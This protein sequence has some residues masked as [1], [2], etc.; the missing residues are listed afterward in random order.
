MRDAVTSAQYENN[1]TLSYKT[2]RR[3]GTPALEINNKLAVMAV[4]GGA[5][6]KSVLYPA[7]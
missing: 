7:N 1:D 6:E 5:I 2:F 4:A 3:L